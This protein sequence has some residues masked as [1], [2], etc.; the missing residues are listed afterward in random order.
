MCATSPNDLPEE[1]AYIDD[2]EYI[3]AMPGHKVPI[4]LCNMTSHGTKWTEPLVD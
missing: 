4:N 1:P 2:N 3:E